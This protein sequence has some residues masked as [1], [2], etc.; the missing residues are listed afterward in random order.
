MKS[1]DVTAGAFALV[2][3]MH[4]F[5]RRGYRKLRDSTNMSESAQ[6]QL[7]VRVTGGIAETHRLTVTDLTTLASVLQTAVRGVALVLTGERAGVGGR[8]KANIEAATELQVFA[9]P[10]QGSF[11]LDIGLAP[12]P[13]A[14]PGAEQPHLG[15]RALSTLIEG[16]D[17]LDGASD[18]L[19]EGFDP[20]VLKTLD[21]LAPV[22]RRG[23][24]IELASRGRTGRQRT[25]IDREWLGTVE[26]LRDKPLR[27]HVRIEGVLQ[28]VDLGASPLQCRIDRAFEAPVPC[29]IPTEFRAQVMA[30]HGKHVE[31]AGEAIFDRGSDQPKRVMVETI[32]RLTRV[33]GIDPERIREHVGWSELAE[34][35]NVRTLDRPEELGGLFESDDEVDEFLAVLRDPGPTLA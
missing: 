14:I 24:K 11:V 31:I 23:H 25:C 18:E 3:T 30:A 15:E 34:R 17:T 29:L 9:E 27:A 12:E 35:Q 6:T 21:R 19:P 13:P 2:L 28:M 32:E 5:G 26:R 8:K 16:I 10:R 33:A 1:C 22:L 7:T 20:G 4:D